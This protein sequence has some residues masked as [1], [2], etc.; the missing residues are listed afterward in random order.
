MRLLNQIN[1][2]SAGYQGGSV[3]D[4]RIRDILDNVC[5]LEKLA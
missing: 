4:E 2:G 5:T 1:L 3:L